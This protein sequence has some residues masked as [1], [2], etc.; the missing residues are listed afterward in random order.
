MKTVLI[1]N[2]YFAKYTGSELHILEI[3]KQFEKKGFDVTIA[4]FQKAYPLLEKAGNMHIV[5]CLTE[6]LEK[7]EFD[8]VFVQHYPV[9]DFVCNKY[10]ILYKKLVVSKLSVIN[11][12]EYLP[13]CTSEADLI[14]CI[15]EECAEKVYQEIGPDARVRVFKNSVSESFFEESNTKE[16]QSNLK[17]IAVISNHVPE[18]LVKLSEVMGEQYFM[19]Y[20]GAEYFPKLVDANLLKNYDLVITIGRTVQQCFALKVPVYV[21]DYFGGPGYINDNNFETAEQNNFSGRGGFERKTAEELKFDIESNYHINSSNLE[22][23]YQIAKNEYS[24][25]INFERVYRELMEN[26]SE[27]YKKME[28]YTRNDS[29]R[30]LV[31]SRAIPSLCFPENIISQLYIDYGEGLKE[32]DSIKW[33][34]SENYTITRKFEFDRKVKEFRFDPCN[35]PAECYIYMVSVNGQIKERFIDKKEEFLHYDPQFLIELTDAEQNQDKTS[36][37]ICYKFKSK[38]SQEVS[39]LMQNKLLEAD[40]RIDVLQKQNRAMREW[41]KTIPKKIIK[42]I[43]GIFKR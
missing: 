1:T 21:Y 24:Y 17:N 10:K 28:F 12:L 14:L 30:M 6:E 43:L 7:Q 38:S 39:V 40:K 37:E 29:L 42:K 3:A 22:K 33:R 36:I 41:Y 5:D 8:V 19:D 35:V 15:S 13:I 20:I 4:V 16:T 31:Y 34:A 23:L 27:E 9:F 18:E 26:D 25:D 11:E 32:D 2:L